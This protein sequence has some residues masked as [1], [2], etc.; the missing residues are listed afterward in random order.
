[1]YESYQEVLELQNK[2]EQL[3]S[4]L[5]AVRAKILLCET[6]SRGIILRLRSLNNEAIA[7]LLLLQNDDVC[8]ESLAVS[9]ASNNM[10]T[11]V[12]WR[13][14][15]DAISERCEAARNAAL[16][17]SERARVATAS[18]ERKI[19]VR[20]QGLN[21][22]RAR[23]QRWNDEFEIRHGRPPVCIITSYMRR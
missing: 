5:H 6:T 21:N 3:D 7:R 18:L 1:L 4:S 17:Q 23:I 8:S 14:A 19:Q 9:P 10:R 20:R 22:Q 13:L 12:L 2:I 15:L 16:Q 11:V